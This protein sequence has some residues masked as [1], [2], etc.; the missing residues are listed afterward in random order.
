MSDLANPYIRCV[1]FPERFRK[2]HFR[3]WCEGIARGKPCPAFLTSL[4]RQIAHTESPRDVAV[5]LPMSCRAPL[6]F[7]VRLVP[8]PFRP[9]VCD[10][11]GEHVPEEVLLRLVVSPE[12][13]RRG[14][15][16]DPAAHQGEDRLAS[17]GHP[18]APVR[19]EGRRPGPG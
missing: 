2:A 17:V 10:L 13:P 12:D 7:R 3:G 9:R 8:E 6:F 4:A 5:P 1:R 11:R 16:S 19:G 14:L 15:L 18:E